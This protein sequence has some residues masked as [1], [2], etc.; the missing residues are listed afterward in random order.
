[1]T[2]ILDDIPLRDVGDLEAEWFRAPHPKP[3]DV[4]EPPPAV[5]SEQLAAADQAAASRSATAPP[6]SPVSSCAK[7]LQAIVI[8]IAGED[9]RPIEHVAFEL[10]KSA[11]E[12]SGTKSGADGTGQFAGIESGSYELA[13]PALDQDAWEI[14]S[15]EATVPEQSA[16]PAAWSAPAAA[17]AAAETTHTIAEGESIAALAL[18]YGFAPETIWDDAANAA[19]KEKRK[20]PNILAAGDSVTIPALRVVARPVNAGASV[21]IRRKGLPQVFRVR[22]LAPDGTPRKELPYL[23]DLEDESGKEQRSGT[24]SGEGFVIEKLSP[25]VRTVTI[26]LGPTGE[27]HRFR[28]ELDPLDTDSGLQDRLRNLGYSCGEEDGAIG[29]ATAEAIRA[30]QRDAG[31]AGNGTAD[32]PTREEL[33]KRHLS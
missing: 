15:S 16:S 19:L 27:V 23:I 5:S 3:E 28:A 2:S 9:G 4:E 12:M 25:L 18:R 1:M 30:F 20:D 14:L 11:T 33:K 22:F 21:R 29:P 24:T 13:L 7:K 26:T 10:R 17:A 32:T 8:T 6:A 31:L